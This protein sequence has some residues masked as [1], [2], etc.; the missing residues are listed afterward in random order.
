[1]AAWFNAAGSVVSVVNV[2]RQGLMATGRAETWGLNWPRSSVGRSYPFDGRNDAF[3]VVVELVNSEGKTIGST[4]VTMRGGWD[5]QWKE[6]NTALL[7]LMP[8][9]QGSQNL[10]FNRVSADLITDRLTVRIAS[11]D[12]VNAE[13]AAKTKGINILREAE[14]IQL[15]EVAALADSRAIARAMQEFALSASGEITEYRGAGGWVGIPD[16]IFG[17]PVTAIGKEAFK[18]KGITGVSI[19]NSVKRIGDLAFADNP[20]TGKVIIP[21]AAIVG[22]AAFMDST[23]FAIAAQLVISPSGEIT[24]YKG[25]GGSIVIPPFSVSGVPVTAIGPEVFAEVASVNQSGYKTYKDGKIT[26][27]TIP[28][29]ITSIGDYAFVNN[30]LTSVTIPSSVTRIGTWAFAGNPLESIT[31]LSR[32]IGG[33]VGFPG[34]F[35]EKNG[36]KAGTY[37]TT[38]TYT[39]NIDVGGFHTALF[40]KWTYT[41]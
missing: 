19:P 36:R 25:S 3:E 10:A 38:T 12:G 37:T 27:V 11:I 35:Y 4:R 8:R 40:A 41:P 39:H 6:Q 33:V 29:G 22:S 16:S 17:I 28:N 31:V 5:V 2:V 34:N 7:R 1:V 24:A 15:P 32:E 13:T 26:S 14:Y 30:L 18:G 23:V 20:L 21:K 9:M